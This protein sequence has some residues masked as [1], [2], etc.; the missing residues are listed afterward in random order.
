MAELTTIT[1]RRLHS[2][3]NDIMG[4]PDRGQAANFI[5]TLCIGA[6]GITLMIAASVIT[7]DASNLQ[8]RVRRLGHGRHD[9]HHHQVTPPSA[10]SSSSALT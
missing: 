1:V 10:R 2:V 6:A 8:D 9:G 3:I 5:L 7:G 4:A